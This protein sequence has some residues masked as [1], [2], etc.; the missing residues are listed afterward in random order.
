MRGGAE[1]AGSALAP[2]PAQGA[3]PE[4]GMWQGELSPLGWRQAQGC[5]GIKDVHAQKWYRASPWGSALFGEGLLQGY[6]IKSFPSHQR[7]HGECVTS[8]RHL[9]SS[10]LVPFSLVG[11]RGSYVAGTACP[12]HSC[13]HLICSNLEEGLHGL[14]CSRNTPPSQRGQNDFHL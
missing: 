1:T 12:L 2:P 7:T 8:S 14:R 13:N 3:A 9:C 6:R 10:R 11:V 4:P 5:P